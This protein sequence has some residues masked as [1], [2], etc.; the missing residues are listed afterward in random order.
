MSNLKVFSAESFY[1]VCLSKGH[2]FAAAFDEIFA[3][4][5][6]AYSIKLLP[7]NTN[8]GMRKIVWTSGTIYD[9]YED[10]AA[11]ATKDYY[12]LNSARQIWK[13]IDNAGS[14][15]STEEP[16]SGESA[17]Y[18][19]TSD[20]YTWKLMNIL[21]ASTLAKFE[22]PTFCPLEIFEEDPIDPNYVIHISATPGEISTIVVESSDTGFESPIVIISGNGKSA[23]AEVVLDEAGRITRV[24]MLNRGMNYSTASAIVVDPT[25]NSNAVLKV[26]LSPNGGH[27][28]D[29]C[30]EL[31]AN[32]VAIAVNLDLDIETL[33]PMTHYGIITSV[34]KFEANT[35][36]N[37]GHTYTYTYVFEVDG[38][39]SIVEAGSFFEFGDFSGRVFYK[40]AVGSTLH[41]NSTSHFYVPLAFPR[42]T[43]ALVDQAE[44]TVRDVYL[45]TASKTFGEILLTHSVPN[46]IQPA[47]GTDKY[48]RQYFRF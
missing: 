20:G 14:A 43:T 32:E 34:K 7:E 15:P 29:A 30:Y 41:V 47:T 33:T 10:N 12:V 24:R 9:Y 23:R 40:D 26:I 2:V 17:D 6:I 13:C 18:I 27:G 21:E 11:L 31:N 42:I 37:D 28:Y 8:R 35:F 44:I 5:N 36:A 25:T 3:R 19:E 39:I 46:P 22:S 1:D 16:F 38:D 48:Y 45:P 4:K